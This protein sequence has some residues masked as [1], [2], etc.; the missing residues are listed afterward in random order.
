MADNNGKKEISRPLDKY[1]SMQAEH[2]EDSANKEMQLLYGSSDRYGIYQLKDNP[3][4]DPFRFV[5]MDSL[6]KRGI[7]K[8]NL[9]VIVPENYD[10]VY[11]GELSDIQGDTQH[12]KLGNVFLKFNQFSDFRVSER[13]ISIA[14]VRD[15][16]CQTYRL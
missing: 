11:V 15:I 3:E 4:L 7:A 12:E 2:V 8:D 5:G 13:C 16:L 10:L 6:V 9:D 1:R 14:L